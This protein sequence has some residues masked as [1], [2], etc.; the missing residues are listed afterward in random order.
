MEDLLEKARRLGTA[1]AEHE[2]FKTFLDA[3]KRLHEDKAAGEAL[4][5]YN[6]AAKA[7]AEKG[8]KAQ[9]VEVVEKQ[10]LERLHGA[11]VSNE[12]VKAF[13]KAQ[14]DYMELMHNVNDAIY[15]QLAPPEAPPGAG[16]KPGGGVQ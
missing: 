14:A 6:K 15:S 2:R 10:R 13:M 16:A 11:V 8:K 7:I 1:L 3:S 5:A 12:T 4:Q 9:P